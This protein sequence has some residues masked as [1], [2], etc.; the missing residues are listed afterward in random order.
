MKPH[1]RQK[2]INSLKLKLAV[3]RYELE[4]ILFAPRHGTELQEK[5][6]EVG[7]LHLALKCWIL[8]TEKKLPDWQHYF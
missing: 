5:A 8:G 1:S 4:Q 6:I 7:Q 3:A 2:K